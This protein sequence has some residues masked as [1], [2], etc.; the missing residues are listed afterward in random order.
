M[1]TFIRQLLSSN[2]ATALR[3]VERRELRVELHPTDYTRVTAAANQLKIPADEF[4]ALALHLGTE[5]ILQQR[6]VQL[7]HGIWIKMPYYA[8]LI[9][10]MKKLAADNEA[11]AMILKSSRL[12]RNPTRQIRSESGQLGSES[13]RCFKGTQRVVKASMAEIHLSQWVDGWPLIRRKLP[14]TQRLFERREWVVNEHSIFPTAAID[15][16]QIEPSTEWRQWDPHLPLACR[17]TNGS[18]GR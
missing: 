1:K 13:Y 8:V 5:T 12:S 6:G 16:R 7:R 3:G 4:Y 18:N 15:D 2:V 9:F 14:L 10:A 11:I 17:W